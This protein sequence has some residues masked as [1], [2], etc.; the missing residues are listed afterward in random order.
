MRQYGLYLGI[1]SIIQELGCPYSKIYYNDRDE[2]EEGIAAI[3]VRSGLLSKYRKLSDASYVNKIDRVQIILQTGRTKEA[4]LGGM[5]FGSKLEDKLP[6]IFNRNLTLDNTKIHFV[7]GQLT[8][9]QDTSDTDIVKNAVL[10]IVR[11]D[12]QSGLINMGK[13]EQGLTLYS[14]NVTINYGIS[15][16]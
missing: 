16:A 11:I 7:N 6:M 13:T 2:I 9:I 15:E 4:I 14:I 3:Y 10:T 8:D 12:P 5:S 1:K